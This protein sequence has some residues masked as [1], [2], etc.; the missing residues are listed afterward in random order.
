MF[1]YLLG[2]VNGLVAQLNYEANLKSQ[3]AE[4]LEDWLLRLD[5]AGKNKRLSN[6]QYKFVTNYLATYWNK[7][8]K[9]ID[10]DRDF[11]MQ[12]PPALRSK[13][14]FPCKLVCIVSDPAPVR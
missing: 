8:I 6:T 5:R 7:N 10:T 13:V 9:G 1:S 14:R 2:N 12:L 3:Q 4:Q 11:I